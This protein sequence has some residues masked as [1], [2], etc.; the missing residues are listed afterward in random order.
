MK[1]TVE[2]RVKVEVEQP[3]NVQ[4]MIAAFQAERS[5]TAELIKDLK[6]RLD[7]K[8]KQPEKKKSK[9]KSVEKKESPIKSHFG[10]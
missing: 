5:E 9:E 1:G 10:G 3:K 7:E 6:T 4:D 2:D 8:E